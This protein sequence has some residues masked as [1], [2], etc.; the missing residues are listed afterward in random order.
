MRPVNDKC[1]TLQ[2]LSKKINLILGL[3]NNTR[4]KNAQI[5]GGTQVPGP[6]HKMRSGWI[7]TTNLRDSAKL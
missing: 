5:I 7:S 3:M 2:K 6:L 4:N 1:C